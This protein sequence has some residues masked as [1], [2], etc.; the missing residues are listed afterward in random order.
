M[1]ALPAGRTAV[2]TGAG[3]GLGRAIASRLA[4]EGYEVVCVDRS[5]ADAE[6]VAAEVGGRALGADVRDEAAAVEL[7]ATLD[8][9]DALI[10]NAGI[11]YFTPLADT[12][13]AQAV[14]VLEVNLV[15]SMTWMKAL[16]PLMGRNGGGAV[17]NL[18]SIACRST[19][20]GVGMYPPAKAAVV[21]LTKMAALEYGPLGV[22]VN[23]V[24]PGMIVTEGTAE[25][26][27]ATPQAQRPRSELIPLGR[28][29]VPADIAGPVAFLCSPAASYMTGQVLW[30][31]GGFSEAGN[32]HFRTAK[33]R[34]P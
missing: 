12:T 18:S 10:N 5:A 4:G 31:D 23:A 30:V 32:D 16:V 8:R 19:A 14:E 20:T 11:W 1:C 25:T 7:A 22:R 34:R 28:L 3:R 29:G 33:A 26:F 21:S 15:A 9:C 17:V 24:G 2:V 6:R 13:I 27:G